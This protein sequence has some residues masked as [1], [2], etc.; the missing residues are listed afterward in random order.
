MQL[1]D[2]KPDCPG[3]DDEANCPTE[4]T[5]THPSGYKLLTT[6]VLDIVLSICV[7]G[8]ELACLRLLVVIVLTVYFLNL[9]CRVEETG[10][11]CVMWHF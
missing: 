8:I 7:S 11:N 6:D 1:C 5:G 3:G 2:G 9:V 4:T 10:E